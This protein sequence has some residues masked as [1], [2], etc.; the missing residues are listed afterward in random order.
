[1]PILGVA[2][3]VFVRAQG[4][5]PLAAFNALYREYAAG[6]YGVVARRIQ[7]GR[8]FQALQPPAT[9]ARLGKWLGKWNPTKAAFV[10]ELADAERLSAAWH[11]L[12][13][14][15]A[16]RLYVI[17]RPT[18]LGQNSADDAFELAWHHTAVALLAE[19]MLCSA[20]NVYLDTL[21]RRYAST[22]VEPH[23]PL[24]PRFV[25]DRGIA[26]EQRCWL[27]R[28]APDPNPADFSTTEVSRADCLKEAIRRFTAAAAVSPVAVEARTRM[29][30]AQFQL[31]ALEDALGTI[32]QAGQTTDSDLTYWTQ[33]FRGRILDALNRPDA[34][35]AFRA[36]LEARPSAQ[37]AT[38]GLALTL[39]KQGRVDDAKQIAGVAK[40]QPPETSDPWWTYLGGDARF[41]PRWRAELRMGLTRQ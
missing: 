5:D 37:S 1:M 31:G 29:A 39:Y 25:L 21:Q 12:A 19:Q 38:I 10:L 15:S 36:A 9:D 24:D 20:E 27:N 30:W 3:A 6:D 35:T 34:E 13:L 41:Y 4:P 33:L 26:Q 14:I 2:A 28:D 40:R 7:S 18:P 16:G 11:S 32:E 8:D 23:S 17:S 22:P